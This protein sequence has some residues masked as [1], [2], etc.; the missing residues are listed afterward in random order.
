LIWDDIFEL[1]RKYN[2]QTESAQSIKQQALAL[3][4][5][6]DNHKEQSYLNLQQLFE[7]K[8]CINGLM[9]S[10]FALSLS[11]RKVLEK[12]SDCKFKATLGKVKR[13]KQARSEPKAQTSNFEKFIKDSNVEM[14]S[15]TDLPA[16]KNAIDLSI[17]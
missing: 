5:L 10:Y 11:H 9:P 3:S 15:F 17:E 12:N 6:K 1:L 8:L 14:L 4:L 7:H 16:K 13:L 2:T